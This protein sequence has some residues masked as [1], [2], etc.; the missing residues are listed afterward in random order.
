[1]TVAQLHVVVDSG[2]SLLDYLTFAAALVAAI[3]ASWAAAWTK[4]QGLAAQRQA[5]AAVGPVLVIDRY[6]ED[7][8]ELTNRGAGVARVL[9]AAI[10]DC[11]LKFEHVIVSAGETSKAMVAPRHAG[12]IPNTFGQCVV[13]STDFS[14]S[15]HYISI[16]WKPAGSGLAF[17]AADIEGPLT[18]RAARTRLAALGVD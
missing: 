8:C 11:A 16:A 7:G 18:A 9:R 10:G 17:V 13:Y 3:V 2:P 5:R 4:R 14:G 15:D 12:A 6:D 1:M